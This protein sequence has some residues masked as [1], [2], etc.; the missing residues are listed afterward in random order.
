MS[1]GQEFWSR[2]ATELNLCY[3]SGESHPVQ[4]T[5]ACLARIEESNPS[6][7]AIV[8]LDVDGALR[9]A[10]ESR[11]RWR[12]GD[13][14]GVLD[15]VPL[16]VKDN[17]FVAGLKATWGSLLFENHVAVM[18]D[19][20]VTRLKDSGAIILGKTNTPEFSLAG[21]TDNRVFG[22]TGN[23][24]A[25]EMSSG[26]SS[27]GAASAVMA[28]MAPLALVTDAG[29][30][31]RRPA[32]HVGCIG[33]KP[34]VNR[35]PRR[36][37]FPML[38]A[39]MQ[40]IGVL[41]RSAKD[42]RAMF[43][44]IGDSVPERRSDASRLKIGA[45]CAIGEHPVEADVKDCWRRAIETLSNL[46]H[47]V[48]EIEA[49]YVPDDMSKLLLDLAAVGIARVVSHHPGWQDKVTGP[50]AALAEKGLVTLAV[51]YD[52]LLKEMAQIRWR[53][54]DLFENVDM[55]LTPTAPVA[56]W[57]R[58]DPY[59]KTIAGA[60]ASARDSGIYTTFVNAA[61]LP[62]ISLPSGLDSRGHPVGVQLVAP[63]NSDSLLLD[64]AEIWEEAAPWEPLAPNR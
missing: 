28:G 41:A 19:I 56:L 17:L 22:S 8:T 40:A 13:Q 59:P 12:K 45:F 58:G 54:R 15:G 14:R 30:S 49:P 63:M 42:A 31:T 47:T 60:T 7:N 64:M 50:M 5:E 24:W 43:N 10:A 48:E 4:V 25:P 57:P 34:S 37:G 23:P 39:D 33:L 1:P 11:E 62:A 32:S 55:L 20:A 36:F 38:A 21:Y 52:D 18:D 9:A 2:T 53:I 6:L 29:G 26:G 44:I 61:G 46:G 35:V 3:Q 16:T 51:D 27:G